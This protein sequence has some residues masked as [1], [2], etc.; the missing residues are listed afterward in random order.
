MGVMLYTA[1]D[2]AFLASILDAPDDDSPR[3]IYA[4]WLDEQGDADRAEFIRV[5]CT[6][7]AAPAG[8]PRRP[9]WRSRQAALLAGHQAEWLGPPRGLFYLWEFRRG[10]LEEV[11]L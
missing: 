10:F 3:L 6:L 5:Q 7:Y 8:D 9:A 4:D 1:A 11:T 2:R